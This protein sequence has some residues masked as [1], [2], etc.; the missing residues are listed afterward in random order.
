MR[1]LPL[2][3]SGFRRFHGDPPAAGKTRKRHLLQ[4]QARKW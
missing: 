4:D 2:F 3:N 1:T